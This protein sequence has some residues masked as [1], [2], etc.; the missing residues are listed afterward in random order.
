MTF[1]GRRIEKVHVTDGPARPQRRLQRDI[2]RVTPSLRQIQF[3]SARSGNRVA[4]HTA[5]CDPIH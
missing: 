1:W 2:S 3:D 4:R 5:A